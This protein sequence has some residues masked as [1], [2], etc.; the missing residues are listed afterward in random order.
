MLHRY[1]LIVNG[2]NYSARVDPPKGPGHTYVLWYWETGSKKRFK[3][4]TNTIMNLMGVSEEKVL[5][6]I[7]EDI[8]NG[9]KD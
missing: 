2:V 8:E 6:I 3:I 4:R 7:K 5:K 9:I 1:K